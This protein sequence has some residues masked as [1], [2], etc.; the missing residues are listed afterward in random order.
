MP[1]RLR[2]IR[3]FMKRHGLVPTSRLARFTLYLFGIDVF[4][5]LYQWIAVK[6]RGPGAASVS[7]W[8]V[9]LSYLSSFL[10]VIVA[11]RWFRKRLMWKLRNRL[12]V[13][14][15]FIGFIPV[16]LLVCMGLLITYLFV[17]QFATYVASSD[18][19]TEIRRLDA[20]NQRLASESATALRQ[21]KPITPSILQNASA[22]EEAFPNR[23]V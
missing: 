21:G 23:T 9:F 11:L 2:Q 20:V 6:L 15:V 17:G 13:T 7:G 12:I 8:I 5:I 22:R 19:Q 4:L 14:Y 3:L 16:V 10:F 1:S 18:L